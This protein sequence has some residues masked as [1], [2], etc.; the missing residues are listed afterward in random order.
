MVN[1]FLKIITL[2]LCVS[3]LKP[4][5]KRLKLIN[6]L[7]IAVRRILSG[8]RRFEITFEATIPYPEVSFPKKH[9]V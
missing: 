2:Y 3:R 4:V 7:L 5:L 9:K 8:I 6:H 1:K